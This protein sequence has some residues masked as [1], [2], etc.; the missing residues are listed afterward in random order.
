[1]SLQKNAF[2]ALS[3]M[4]VVGCIGL[5]PAAQAADPASAPAAA[6]T[7]LTKEQI[8]QTIHD[9]IMNNPK[10]IMESV[11]N[12]QRKNMRDRE[13]HASEDV[14]K[15]R[16]VLTKDASSPEAGDPKGDVTVVE[17]FDYNCHF[18]KGSFPAVQSLL[19]KDK[20]V[21]VVFKEFP[22]LGPSSETAAKWA[23][24]ADKQKKYFEFHKAM[25]DNK[26]QINDELLER[27]A[28]SV[29]MD[30]DKAKM[31]ISSP[32]VAGQLAK[33]RALA[34]QLDING[35]PAFIIGDD[36]SRG[37]IPEDEMEQKITAIRAA[38]GKK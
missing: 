13:A 31:D 10:L 25:M 34:E 12:F 17:F 24:A 38:A 8:D 11:D 7:A 3:L 15:N 22:I 26:E 33:N 21:R 5:A 18:C 6:T 16:D 1:M 9:Y 28:K 14:K 37:A 2:S 20:K 23:L 19:D 35:T 30:V 27:V 32:D 4:A 29:G 36:I